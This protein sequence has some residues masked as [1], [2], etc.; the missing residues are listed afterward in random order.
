VAASDGEALGRN[1]AFASG[2]HCGG[3]NYQEDEL[4]IDGERR[5]VSEEE[6][7]SRPGHGPVSAHL[8]RKGSRDRPIWRGR[9]AEIDG[10]TG[11]VRAGRSG[12]EGRVGPCCVAY[13]RYPSVTNL[14][15]GVGRYMR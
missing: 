1:K 9:A 13:V 8:E 5:R 10:E 11:E 3:Y 6:E 7:E 4:A 14:W 2:G 15:A 12:E